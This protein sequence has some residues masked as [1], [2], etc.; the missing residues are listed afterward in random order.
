MNPSYNNNKQ[1]HH[2][3]LNQQQQ[4]QTEL[5]HAKFKN[6]LV[7]N[8]KMLINIESKGRARE[9]ACSSKSK[10]NPGKGRER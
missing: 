6:M 8:F 1:Q 5:L 4:N 2:Q 9:H 3:Q 7:L 10:V